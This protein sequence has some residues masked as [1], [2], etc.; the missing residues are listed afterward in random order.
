MSSIPRATLVRSVLA[1]VLCLLALSGCTNEADPVP[2]ACV[3]EPA[4]MLAALDA[5]PAAVML[6]DGTPL[7]RCISRA[8]TDGELQSLGV[9]FTRLADT[10]RARAASDP[11][12]ALR[13]GYL[14]GSVR[15][16]ASEATSGVATQL[17]RRIERLATLPTGAV[18][19]SAAAFER[20]LRAGEA[21]G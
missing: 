15:A 11:A 1:V 7:S 12:A 3:G 18:A 4:A 14:A 2:E 6:A 21:S 13:L 9:S 19:A 8:R 20:G 16:G 5:A 10:L 17:A